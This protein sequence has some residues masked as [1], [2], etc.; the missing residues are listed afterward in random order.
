MQPRVVALRKGRLTGSKLSGLLRLKSRTVRKYRI[1]TRKPRPPSARKQEVHD[2]E[3]SMRTLHCA[4]SA[5]SS[6]HHGRLLR[7]KVLATIR[8][9]PSVLLRM[10]RTPPKGRKVCERGPRIKCPAKD[11]RPYAHWKFYYVPQTYREIYIAAIET[12]SPSRGGLATWY[13]NCKLGPAVLNIPTTLLT[14]SS[15][16]HLYS[17]FKELQGDLIE[18]S[19]AVVASAQN[20]HPGE[21]GSSNTR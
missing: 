10:E 15:S 8:T 13:W 5:T 3:G 16:S 7:R 19:H 21:G 14:R 12:S 1:I 11:K 18:A 9:S 6:L 20:L 2:T 17:E 4:R